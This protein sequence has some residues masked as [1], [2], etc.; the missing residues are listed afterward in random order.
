MNV[1]EVLDVLTKAAQAAGPVDQSFHAQADPAYIR[2]MV[3]NQAGPP[4]KFRN[5]VNFLRDT[6]QGVGRSVA[7][8]VRKQFPGRRQPASQAQPEKQPAPAVTNAPAAAPDAG[9]SAAPRPAAPAGVP[10]PVVKTAAWA[11]FSDACLAEGVDPDAL[12]KDAVSV[13]APEPWFRPGFGMPDIKGDAKRML[14]DLARRLRQRKNDGKRPVIGAQG[15]LLKDASYGDR[16]DDRPGFLRRTVGGGIRGAA[17]GAGIAGGIGAGYGALNLRAYSK[18]PAA[19]GLPEPGS[20]EML[21][22]YLRQ[23]LAGAKGNL[24]SGAQIGAILGGITG[25]AR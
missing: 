23:M 20:K 15:A 24:G 21:K 10:N 22:L 6:A 17:A 11:G 8:S 16:D 13:S 7:R 14:S 4:S 12:L 5:N 2:A 3:A 18:N 19:V 25:A 9:A 1:K